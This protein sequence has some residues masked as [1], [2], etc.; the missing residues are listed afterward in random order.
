[1]TSFEPVTDIPGP[2]LLDKGQRLAPFCILQRT[3][4]ASLISLGSQGFDVADHRR[5]L[6]VDFTPAFLADVV[7]ALMAEGRCRPEAAGCKP[8]RQHPHIPG[9]HQLQCPLEQAFFQ[10]ADTA[11]PGFRSSAVLPRSHG[12]AAAHSPGR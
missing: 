4:S 12:A 6:P 11:L 10:L 5:Q 7:H 2:G 1:M 3:I 8:G 9:S